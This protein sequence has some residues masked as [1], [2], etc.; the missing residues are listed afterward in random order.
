MFFTCPSHVPHVT[1]SPG[2]SA[3]ERGDDYIQTQHDVKVRVDRI[4]RIYGDGGVVV[5]FEERKEKDIRLAQR[6]AFFAG[7]DV[8]MITP[9]RFDKSSQAI[10][11]PHNLL[12]R[13]PAGRFILYTYCSPC[14]ISLFSS[15]VTEM[16]SI[17][18]LFSPLNLSL[19]T[20]LYPS[21]SPLLI[22]S[23]SHPCLLRFIPLY[24]SS[25]PL[26]LSP[27]LPKSS[28]LPPSP[29]TPR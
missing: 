8:L 5:H 28:H 9:T 22:P 6:L 12:S 24:P 13:V 1:L 10:A 29:T 26:L 19:S 25:Y 7:S 23:L 18:S 17:P 27:P 3:L 2:I 16:G 11:S 4:N 15:S 21:L 20:P 14:C